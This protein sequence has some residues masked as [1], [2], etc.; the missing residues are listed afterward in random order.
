MKRIP[1]FSKKF[2]IPEIY[3]VLRYLGYIDRN[4]K[5]TYIND[6]NELMQ[7]IELAIGKQT[8]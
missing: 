1:D 7:F 2:S 5:K 4:I 3:G 8:K 6:E